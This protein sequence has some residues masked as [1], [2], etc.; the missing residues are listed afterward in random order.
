M[1]T[2]AGSYTVGPVS[3]AYFD[4]KSGSYKTIASD[5]VTVTIQET[6]P[7]GAQLPAIGAQAEPQAPKPDSQAAKTEARDQEAGIKGQQVLPPSP[8]APLPTDPLSGSNRAFIPLPPGA[9]VALLCLPFA[10]LACL[11]AYF[12]AHRALQ[13]DPMRPRREAAARLKKTLHLLPSTGHR[14]PLTV[15]LLN[16]QRD[17]ALM[18]GIVHAA[19]TADSIDALSVQASSKPGKYAPDFALWT[20]LWR[21]ADLVLYSTDASL[22]SDWQTKAR[23][24]LASMR[25]PGFPFITTLAPRHLM[26]WW[27]AATLLICLFAPVSLK[28]DSGAPVAATE[29]QS[30]NGETK[31][32]FAAYASGNFSA[33]EQI[34]RASIAVKPTDWRARHNLGLALLQQG[35]SSEAVAQLA[36]AFVQHPRSDAA[37][38][39]LLLA[40]E[41][42]GFAPQ[43]IGAIAQNHPVS[44]LA[45]QASPL[46]WQLILAVACALAAF[47]LGLALWAGY[48]NAMPLLGGQAM[49]S[50]K[51]RR[52]ALAA[53]ILSLLGLSIVIAA[54]SLSSLHA[55][56]TAA[57]RR[58]ALVWQSTVLRSIPTEADSSQKTSALQAGSLAVVDRS[59]LGWRHLRF[60]EGES[61]WV[62]NEDLIHLWK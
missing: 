59:F 19:P 27:F 30:S 2:T 16:W 38:D 1:P 24:A 7:Q 4:P 41:Q 11:W 5:I 29:L 36:V 12:A 42:A 53:V 60:P 21:D 9:F 32:P 34:W 44:E 8:P 47:A 14:P 43:A 37:Q 33:A 25:I 50:T 35:S 10:A 39:N 45:R 17:T 28:A 40:M 31:D 3:F 22:P 48:R 54:A 6:A 26:P 13:A 46:E 56:G 62:R 61:G 51:N 15:L 55:Y 57:D 18:L 58:A 52:R 20:S 23:N 49:L